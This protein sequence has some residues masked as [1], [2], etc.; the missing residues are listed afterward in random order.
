MTVQGSHQAFSTSGRPDLQL[1]H[2]THSTL[3]VLLSYLHASPVHE[4]QNSWMRTEES[5]WRV[6]KS[7]FLD[8]NRTYLEMITNIELLIK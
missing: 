7:P 3:A 2:L 5:K 1:L 4:L 6:L 8:S